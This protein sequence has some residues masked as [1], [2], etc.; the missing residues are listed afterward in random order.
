MHRHSAI[1]NHR[2]YEGITETRCGVGELRL[3][4]GQEMARG[5]FTCLLGRGQNRPL[6]RGACPD[7]RRL[8][9]AYH[10]E[11]VLP[12]FRQVSRRLFTG[13]REVPGE[14]GVDDVQVF[15]A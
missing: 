9:P 2:A 12:G 14:H 3:D 7:G 6:R 10:P 13:K 11:G 4:G 5:P 1:L 15:A 8:C